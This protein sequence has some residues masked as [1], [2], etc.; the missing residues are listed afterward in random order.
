MAGCCWVAFVVGTKDALLPVEQECN[1]EEL[2]DNIGLVTGMYDGML[3]AGGNAPWK[4]VGHVSSMTRE[5][6]LAE[7][8][9]ASSDKSRRVWVHVT[10]SAY[11]AVLT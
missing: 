9:T 11:D 3:V 7:A 8:G 6:A 4:V 10:R 2:S 5:V 1:F